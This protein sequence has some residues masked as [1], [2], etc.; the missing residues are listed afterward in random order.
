MVQFHYISPQ[1]QLQQVKKCIGTYRII[2]TS[3]KV[4]FYHT[5]TSDLDLVLCNAQ[6]KNTIKVPETL[7]KPFIIP[8]QLRESGSRDCKGRGSQLHFFTQLFTFYFVCLLFSCYYYANKMSNLNKCQ[9][10]SEL[11]IWWFQF[12]PCTNMLEKTKINFVNTSE[13]ESRSNTKKVAIREEDKIKEFMEK[14]V[15]PYPHCV[16][17]KN[18]TFFI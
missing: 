7:N 13:I 5:I 2:L 3:K 8:S 9:Q 6:F 14:V 15:K 17:C 4:Y 10:L 16:V 11:C 1:Q 18:K 12:L